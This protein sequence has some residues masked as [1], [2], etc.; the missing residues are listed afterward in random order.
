[1]ADE[2]KK[3]E[4]AHGGPR[5]GAGRPKGGHNAR[6]THAVQFERQMVDLIGDNFRLAFN[7]MCRI[8]LHGEKEADRLKALEMFFNRVLGKPKETINVTND[9]PT[10]ELPEWTD[11]E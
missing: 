8:M 1:M 11:D 7:E 3:P 10:S 4:K 5:R 2:Q 6:P 9:A